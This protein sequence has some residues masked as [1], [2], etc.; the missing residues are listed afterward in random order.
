[1]PRQLVFTL[2]TRPKKSATSPPDDSNRHSI[3]MRGTDQ[4]KYI[5]ILTLHVFWGDMQRAN[6]E[7]DNKNLW[8]LP[9]PLRQPKEHKT[10]ELVLKTSIPTKDDPHKHTRYERDSIATE[11]ASR[12]LRALRKRW[13]GPSRLLVVRYTGSLRVLQIP[14]PMKPTRVTNL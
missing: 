8:Y 4:T 6:K 1:M 3:F 14:P 9:K 2:E 5:E 10:E 7:S 13:D 11:Q 12:K